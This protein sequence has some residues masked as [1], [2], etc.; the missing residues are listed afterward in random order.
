MIVF[1]IIKYIT[2]NLC[3]GNYGF[4]QQF[5]QYLPYFYL[6]Y[7]TI[8]L[9]TK[10][11][12]FPTNKIGILIASIIIICCNI[13]L[14]YETIDDRFSTKLS[15]LIFKNFLSISTIYWFFAITNRYISF[16]IKHSD[17]WGK[18]NK[19]SYGIYVFHHWI[20]FLVLGNEIILTYIQDFAQIHYIIFPFILL[21]SIFGI[22][23]IITQILLKTKVERF[24]IG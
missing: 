23:Y 2:S 11:S 12:Q 10:R 20:I 9:L 17:I 13:I 8:Y 22:S 19:S 7:L 21:I 5:I 16:I 3:Y 4:I 15:V 6:G 18:I 24:L 1:F 14:Y